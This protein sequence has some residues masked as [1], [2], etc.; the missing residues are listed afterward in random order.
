[1]R[2]PR[3]FKEVRQGPTTAIV[4]ED[5]VPHL[6][7]LL[8]VRNAAP[9]EPTG[10]AGR[11]SI[12]AVPRLLVDGSRILVRHARRGGLIGRFIPDIFW[13]RCRPFRE[14][15]VAE[16][17]RAHGVPTAEV[18]AAVRTRVLGPFYR[19]AVYTRELRD[20]SDL[21]SYL[22]SLANRHDAASLRNKRATLS[23][24]G[25][26][27]RLAHDAGLYHGD[28]Q[29][30]NV[31]VRHDER[32]AVFLVDLD[33]AGW[34]QPLPRICRAMNLLRL[35]RSAAKAARSALCITRTDMVRF[36]KG[37]TS[38][39]GAGALRSYWR[40]PLLK[41]LYRIKWALSDALCHAAGGPAQRSKE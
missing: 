20:A 4:R 1:M 40:M 41:T 28:L 7:A 17:A 19:G 8:P 9:L 36:L 29:L 5:L 33:K 31:L 16:R 18:V 30:R 23:E 32:P 38:A 25:R 39:A 26:V 10:L 22:A 27:V 13:W 34:R 6:E 24:A 3:S 14:L 15:E 21:H 37:Y 11:G 12:G 2:L 35:S